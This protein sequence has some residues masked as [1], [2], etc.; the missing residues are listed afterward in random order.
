[1]IASIDETKCDG[2]GICIEACPIDTLRMDEKGE[3]AVIK[4][5][6]DCMTCYACELKC[7]TG[8]IYVHPF[9]EVLPRAI[10][11]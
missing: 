4:Y 10:T 8:A 9:K 2:C 1:M 6:D 3:K 11:Y 7:P 5:P